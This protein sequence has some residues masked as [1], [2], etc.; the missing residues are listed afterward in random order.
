MNRLTYS[1][2]LMLSV[3]LIVLWVTSSSV[4]LEMN[5]PKGEVTAAPPV[6]IKILIRTGT[7]G[8]A[9]RKLAEL[10]EAQTNIRIECIEIGRDGY[11]TALG[12]QLFAGSETFDVVAMP[13]TSI[14]Q[15]ASVKAILPLDFFIYDKEMTDRN[16][17]DISDFLRIYTY[18]GF[19]YGLPIDISTHLLYYRNDLIPKPPETWEELIETAKSFSRSRN[20]ASPTVWGLGMP[21]TA[22]EERTKIFMSLLRSFGG[23]TLRERD[24]EVMFDSEDS[25]QAGKYMEKI[26]REGIVPRDMLTWD[27]ARTQEALLTGEIA[28]AAPFWNDVYAAIKESGSP[29]AEKIS[30]APIPGEAASDG[31]VYRSAFQ[32][33]WMLSINAHSK[34]PKE[35]WKFVEFAT[36]KQGG[37]VNASLGGVPARRS[38]LNDPAFQGIRADFP[39]LLKS[40]ESSQK[41][42]SVAYYA[43]LVEL[44]EEAIAKVVSGYATPN[45]AFIHAADE[46]RKI[47]AKANIRNQKEDLR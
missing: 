25:I 17:F 35:A 6:T 27:S 8:E 33:S 46:M 2:V 12:T 29:L 15:F 24:E 13:N 44:E 11:F 41:E 34:Y 20:S 42:P 23:D 45:Q 1:R 14:A 40:M 36:S 4:L 26:I 10:Y 3:A 21:G 30:I 43:S 16:Q 19:I 7:E 47:T 31:K 18:R 38:I 22:P 9:V 37:L 32:Q 5:V 28:M 39:L